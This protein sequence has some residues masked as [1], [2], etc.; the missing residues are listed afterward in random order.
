MMALK[1]SWSEYFTVRN[2][3]AFKFNFS[4]TLSN[5]F[6]ILQGENAVSCFSP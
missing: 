2:A 4:Q 6:M 3:E 5:G 1:A